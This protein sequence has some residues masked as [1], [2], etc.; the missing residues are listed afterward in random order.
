M[1][2]EMLQ[3]GLLVIIVCNE[4]QNF[5]W[6]PSWSPAYPLGIVVRKTQIGAKEMWEVK[7]SGRTA[8]L[9]EAKNLVPLIIVPLEDRD[10]MPREL[11][12]KRQVAIFEMLAN[13]CYEND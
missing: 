5:E 2:P 12:F 7:T 1:V 10:L 3:E 13:F 9:T 4:P 11:L 8:H 6:D